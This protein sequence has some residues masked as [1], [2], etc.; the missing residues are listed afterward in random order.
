MCVVA[1]T[2]A[3]SFTHPAV[4]AG[5]VLHFVRDAS[6]TLA[7]APTRPLPVPLCACALSAFVGS[8]VFGK[9][10]FVPTHP[11]VS[12]V[13]RLLVGRARVKQSDLKPPRY[14]LRFVHADIIHVGLETIAFRRGRLRPR[15]ACDR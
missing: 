6:Y 5:P 13:S 4:R 14:S 2:A 10:R 7:N 3:V 9:F 12:S 15:K 8:W 11:C 1:G